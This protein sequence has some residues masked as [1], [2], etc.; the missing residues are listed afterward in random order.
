M[1]LVI[2]YIAP[3]HFSNHLMTRSKGNFSDL[4]SHC[5]KERISSLL[6]TTQHHPHDKS[7]HIKA[8]GGSGTGT[9]EKFSTKA[10]I[11]Y[12]ADSF[13]L[14]PSP[15][16]PPPHYIGEDTAMQLTVVPEVETDVCPAECHLVHPHQQL[17]ALRRGEGHLAVLKGS[18]R[19]ILHQPI[20]TAWESH[21]VIMHTCLQL[22]GG[23]THTTDSYAM[24]SI[25][26]YA[27]YS[28]DSSPML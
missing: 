8:R 22:V 11:S 20:R 4:F 28:R 18:P 19:A 6:A 14:V 16:E 7:R 25:L 17:V 24:Q 10:L 1:K 3:T 26:K 23:A 15:P 27:Y 9:P 13:Y 12:G 2:H 21:I 5:E